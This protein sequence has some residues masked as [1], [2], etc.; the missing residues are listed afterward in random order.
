MSF[1]PLPSL[2]QPRRLQRQ[3]FCRMQCSRYPY[4]ATVDTSIGS[5][6]GG[7]PCDLE[8]LLFFFFFRFFFTPLYPLILSR[9]L[10]ESWWLMVYGLEFWWNCKWYI[11]NLGLYVVVIIRSGFVSEH[12]NMNKLKQIPFGRQKCQSYFYFGHSPL[13]I[14]ET[15]LE[16]S[17]SRAD[18]NTV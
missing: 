12:W 14:L 18:H 5:A 9:S 1:V 13:S 6:P 11:D 7:F 10:S 4:T 16:S 8:F 2:L 15:Q 3:L 17:K